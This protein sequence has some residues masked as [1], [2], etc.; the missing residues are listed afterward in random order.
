MKPIKPH[1]SL[2][3]NFQLGDP[4]RRN[5]GRTA[6]AVSHPSLATRHSCAFTLLELLVVIGIIAILAS[7]LFPSLAKAK[8][9]AQSTACLNN[10]RQLQLAYLQYAQEHNESLPPNISRRP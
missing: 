6:S 4:S 1:L 10:L 3:P 7:L 8:S 5:L 2:T 9:K